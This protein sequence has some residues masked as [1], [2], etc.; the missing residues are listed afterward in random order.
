M[1]KNINYFIVL[2]FQKSPVT[3]LL[4]TVWGDK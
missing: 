4:F 3:I 1:L 2:Y